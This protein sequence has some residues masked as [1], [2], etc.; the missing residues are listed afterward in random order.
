M[1]E[2]LAAAKNNDLPEAEVRKLLSEVRRSYGP[3]AR[4]A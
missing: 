2:Y 4:S 3:V 1:R